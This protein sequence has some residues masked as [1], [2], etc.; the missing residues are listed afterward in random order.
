MLQ[1]IWTPID[2]GGA[3]CILKVG[4]GRGSGS[5]PPLPPKSCPILA[6]QLSKS[7]HQYGVA[8]WRQ[9][10]WSSA[11]S[12]LPRFLV[13]SDYNGWW[14]TTVV[15]NDSYVDIM[16]F[17]KNIFWSSLSVMKIPVLNPIQSNPMNRSHYYSCSCVF[18]FSDLIL[19]SVIIL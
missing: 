10:G 6:T 4:K 15:G 16:G 7:C 14:N 2:T 13:F 19:E 9:R 11:P 3:N 8:L 1:S 18:S 12:S 5:L 17:H